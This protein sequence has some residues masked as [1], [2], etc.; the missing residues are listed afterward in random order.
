MSYFDKVAKVKKEVF[1]K[2][3]LEEYCN[4]GYTDFLMFLQQVLNHGGFYS[5]LPTF[6]SDENI[7]EHACSWSDVN[8]MDEALA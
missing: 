4:S 7:A 5:S 3:I 2:I 6:V 1:M 8:K